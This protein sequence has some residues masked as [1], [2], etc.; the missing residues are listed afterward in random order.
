[1]T[2]QED[3]E[4]PLPAP[5]LLLLSAESADELDRE[6]AALADRLETY[7]ELELSDLAAF[8]QLEAPGLPYRRFVVARRSAEAAEL[9]REGHAESRPAVPGR[10]VVFLFSG[11]ADHYVDMAAGLYASEPV[12]RAELRECF[13]LLEPELGF[14]LERLL[15]PRGPEAAAQEAEE[16]VAAP[17]DLKKLFAPVEPSPLDRTL[18]AQPLL[19]ALQYALA[20]LWIHYGVAPAALA[21]YS[22][23]E[24]VAA[25]HAGVLPLAEALELVARRARLVES[26]PPGAMLSV[27]TSVDRVREHLEED[28]SVAAAAGPMLTVLSGR[29]AVVADVEARL[30]AAGIASRRLPTTHAYH[31]TLM[32]PVADGLRELV[33]GYELLPPAIPFLSNVT[34]TWISDEEATSHDYWVDHLC[35]TIRFGDNAHELWRLSSPLFLELGPGDSLRALVMQHRPADGAGDAQL[36][37]S[38]RSRLADGSDR[39]LFLTTLGSLWAAGVPVAL[40][41]L[42]AQTRAAVRSV[43]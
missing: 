21:G 10:P 27:A 32:E 43:D 1:M 31:S 24:Y 5:Q 14:D 8:S 6:A 35:R 34:G 15:Y 28:V 18:V 9:L 40:A 23:G 39:T 42:G 3:T 2:S 12:F 38:L 29:E 36:L 11:V 37:G 41:S 19:F 4:M 33:A 25:C 17:F 20:R 16:G 13:E 7:S 30:A 22:I 26:S